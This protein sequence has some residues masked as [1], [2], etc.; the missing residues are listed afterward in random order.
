MAIDVAIDVAIELIFLLGIDFYLR[1]EAGPIRCLLHTIITGYGNQGGAALR[2]VGGQLFILFLYF[3]APWR[4]DVAGSFSTAF[5]AD[6]P[7]IN[8]VCLVL[9][10][11]PRANSYRLAQVACKSPG[12][13]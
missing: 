4:R 1:G 11:V 6:K 9:R 5:R 12:S 7:A 2:H 3:I 10:A 8:I 13:W